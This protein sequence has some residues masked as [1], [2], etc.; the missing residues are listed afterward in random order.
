MFSKQYLMTQGEEV[1]LKLDI[2]TEQLKILEILMRIYRK[3]PTEQL[4]TSIREIK[5]NY[6]IHKKTN[7]L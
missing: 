5:T 6:D 3:N 4:E 2:A 1:A 7:N